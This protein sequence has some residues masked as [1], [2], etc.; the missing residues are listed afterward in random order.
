M[1]YTDI[2]L[3]VMHTAWRVF[4]TLING[5]KPILFAENNG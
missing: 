4:E 5:V 3:P 2:K 1:F